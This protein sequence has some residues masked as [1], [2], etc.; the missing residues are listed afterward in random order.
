MKGWRQGPFTCIIF[1]FCERALFFVPCFV[2]SQEEYLQNWLHLVTLGVENINVIESQPYTCAIVVY[3][4]HRDAAMARRSLIPIKHE[5][6]GPEV[7]VDWADPR[8]DFKKHN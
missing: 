5:L 2:F 4:S 7:I 8:F 6:F 3:R 1:Y